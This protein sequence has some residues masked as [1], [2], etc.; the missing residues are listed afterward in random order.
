MFSWP[1]ATT[2]DDQDVDHFVT[3][4]VIGSGSF[5]LH[6]KVV[7]QSDAPQFT[8][9]GEQ[10]LNGRPALRWDY[11]VDRSH[12]GFVRTFDRQATLGTH[13]SFW[14]DATR[15]TWSGWTSRLTIFRRNSN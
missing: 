14:V 11:T 1:G 2:F 10:V 5:A 3:G 6:A 8:W 7:F 9:V 13:G 15:S 4:G 12:G